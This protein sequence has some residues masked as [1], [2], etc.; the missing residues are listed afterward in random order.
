MISVRRLLWEAGYR[1]GIAPWDT[2]RPIPMLVDAV[3]GPDG[4]RPG[5]ALDLGC[6]TGRN[7]IYLAGRGWDV[8]GVDLSGHAVAVG[9]RRAAA[10]GV[11][12]RLVQGDVTRLEDMDLGA[13]FTLLVDSGCYHV[14]PTGRRGAY[15]AAVTQVAAPGACLLLYGVGR[16]PFPGVGTSAAEMRR[17]F[18]GW[19]LVSAEQIPATELR[20]YIDTR[21]PFDL[22][23]AQRW[24]DA[25]R[26]R[27]ERV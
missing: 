27:L 25:W 9:L 24:F 16:A 12:V 23:L 5:R 3:E 20:R 10:A 1:L 26:Y 13:G 15:A 19:R 7:A 17:R 4:L 14:V 18:T 21:W 11:S 6:G 2:G 8:C 22:A